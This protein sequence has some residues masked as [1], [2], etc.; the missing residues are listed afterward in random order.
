LP[1]IT[2]LMPVH[3]GGQFLRPAIES[4]LRQTLMDF[5]FLI[6][7]D[8]SEDD[9]AGII[10]SYQDPRIRC[11]RNG[12]CQGVGKSLN[13]GLDMIRTEYVVRM[14]ADDISA[15]RRLEWQVHY[16]RRNPHI[17]V[18]GTWIKAFG[19]PASSGK[20]EGLTEPS[21]IKSL[22]LFCNPLYHPSVIIRKSCFDA[23]RL[24]YDPT[25]NRCEDY[26]LWLRSAPLFDI[27]NIHRVGLYWR[28]H[29]ENVT[30]SHGD[31]MVEQVLQLQADQL[32]K[33][34]MTVNRDELYFHYCL[35]AGKR[36]S[37]LPE[38]KNAESWLARVREAM[39]VSSSFPDAGVHEAIGY[40]WFWVCAHSASL[41]PWMVN[42]Y[43]SADLHTGYH[44][45]FRQWMIF[46]SS[47]LWHHGINRFKSHFSAR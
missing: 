24:R 4:I 35:G 7:D 43:F 15:R 41:S 22:M 11:V 47:I 25:F 12:V 13:Q 20:V 1:E 9:T 19:D 21:S 33:I 26:D 45:S 2:V 36:L 32:K 14:D 31:V 40:V 18:S 23:N 30:V 3:N 6:L 27:G 38:L 42:R 37:S 34:G 16:M 28:K 10:A 46:F 8:A 29:L 5:E 39:L 17:G 44:P